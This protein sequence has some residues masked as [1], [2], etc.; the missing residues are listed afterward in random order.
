MYAAASADAP[1]NNEFRLRY[2]DML[3]RAGKIGPAR[4]LLTRGLATASDPMEIRRGLGAIHVLSGQSGQAIAELDMVLAAHPNDARALVDK[5][6][7][8]D[9]Q[10]NH[11][12]AQRLYIQARSA[13]PDDAVIANNLALS[14]AL[15]GRVRE[16]R[17]LLLPYRDAGN[18]PERVNVTI[19]ILS[20]AISE[21]D[22]SRVADGAGLGDDAIKRMALAFAS[23]A[24]T[25]GQ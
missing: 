16:A 1:A 20:A 11:A 7:A 9:L 10:G 14:M 8:L 19:R 12:D 15:Q 2:A 6:V 25:T 22:P 13:A 3:L 18:A 24:R 21:Q 5:A 17:D 23:A 4:D